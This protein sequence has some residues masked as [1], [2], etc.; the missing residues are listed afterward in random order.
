MNQTSKD[1]IKEQ[2]KEE[3]GE[4]RDNLI[5][6]EEHLKILL[7]PKD[8]EDDKNTILE[9]RSGTGGD[10]AALFAGNLYRMYL[11][12][13]ERNSWKTEIITMNDRDKIRLTTLSHGSG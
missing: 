7:I 1:E 2:V 9:I 3:I 4:L 5:K 13:A 12:Y 6:Q 11:R 8:P 10:E